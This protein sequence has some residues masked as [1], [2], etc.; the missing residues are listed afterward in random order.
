M[1]HFSAVGE[2]SER[3]VFLVPQQN[4]WVDVGSGSFPKL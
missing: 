1:P 3:K 4:L 2:P